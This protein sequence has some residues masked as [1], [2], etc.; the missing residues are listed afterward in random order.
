MVEVRNSRIQRKSR[1]EPSEAVFTQ[2]EPQPDSSRTERI[3]ALVADH[4]AGEA[5]QDWCEGRA[6]WPLCHVPTGGGRGA[7]GAVPENLGLDR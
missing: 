2:A 1:L 7:E 6:T 4:G 5:H 3:G